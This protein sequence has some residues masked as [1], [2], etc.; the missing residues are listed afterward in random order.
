L[1]D[2]DTDAE[3]KAEQHAEADANRRNPDAVSEDVVDDKIAV[4]I[5]C[6]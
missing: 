1:P 4:A 6:W 2:Q 3:D 5:H